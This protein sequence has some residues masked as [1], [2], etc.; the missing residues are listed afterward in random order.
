MHFSMSS[1]TAVSGLIS[2]NTTWSYANSPYIVTDNIL[3]QNGATLTIEPGVTIKMLSDTEFQVRGELI[4]QGTSSSKITFTSN[5]SSPAAGDWGKLYFFDEAT[6]ASFSDN[7]YT[8]GSILEYCIVEYAQE[9]YTQS[10]APYVHYS[11]FR[12]NSERGIKSEGSPGIRINNCDIHHNYKGIEIS[13]SN[14]LIDYN[15][16]RDNTPGGGGYISGGFY[17]NT[18]KNNTVSTDNNNYCHD[19]G[20]GIKFGGGVF[21]HNII[22]GNSGGD[23]AFF[24][25][26]SSGEVTN[27]II[28]N[29]DSDD[30]A[31]EIDNDGPTTFTHNIVIGKTNFDGISFEKLA[32]DLF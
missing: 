19:C 26:T 13:D 22:S 20:G 30:D 14:S 5:A 24:L 21:D 12:Y 1:G 3:L 27:N 32:D 8:G 10:S 16:I 23:A 7:T 17:Y 29:N 18:I 31:V 2:S 15:T 6:D 11:E 25:N 9:L 4:A 28:F